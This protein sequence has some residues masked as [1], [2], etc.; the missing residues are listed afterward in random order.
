MPTNAKKPAPDEFYAGITVGDLRRQLEIFDA[1][2]A[3]F[4]DGLRFYRL[5]RRGAKLVAVEFQEVVHRDDTG[6]LIAHDLERVGA[7]DGWKS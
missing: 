7:G 4:M 3:L 2:A 1:D 6:R 5:K